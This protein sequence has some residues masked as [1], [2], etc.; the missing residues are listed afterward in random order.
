[1]QVIQ[2]DSLD[3]ALSKG[4]FYLLE[5]GEE[6]DSRN[7]KVL[8]APTPVTTEYFNPRRRVLFNAK[9]DANPFFHFLESLWMLAGRRDAAWIAAFNKRMHEYSD[10][11]DLHGAYGYRW[12]KHFALDGDSTTDGS[13]TIDQIDTII[14]LLTK[15]PLD[16][17]IVLNM[18]DPMSDL[19]ANYKDLPCN[20]HVYFRVRG[21]LLDM[22]VCNR[23][24]DIIW[25]AYGANAVHMS[26]LQEYVASRVGLRVGKYYQ[27]SNNYHLYVDVFEKM[28]GVHPQRGDHS[29]VIFAVS[30]PKTYN[31]YE[32]VRECQDLD[33]FPLVAN[34]DAE[35]PR[36]MDEAV[37]CRF[38]DSYKSWTL[39]NLAIP[40]VKAYAMFR[41]KDF[42]SAK[43]IVSTMPSCDWRLACREWLERREQNHAN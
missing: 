10:D 1:M 43:G 24:N 23:S 26:I 25:G 7:G 17:R 37:D 32:T 8:V 28:F 11:G 29:Q 9:R 33:I 18:W 42:D 5:K 36:F 20:T 4:L 12:R 30:S 27:V 2:A 41:Q 19:A 16:R 35:L 3:L 31:M 40:M 22:T 13:G 38:S 15:N 14:D 39:N 6:Q 34:F 21:G